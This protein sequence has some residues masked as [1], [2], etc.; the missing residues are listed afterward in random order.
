MAEDSKVSTESGKRSTKSTV[1]LT[2]AQALEILQQ[3]VINCQHAGIDASVA[4]LHGS[5][6]PTVA[7]VLANTKIVDG[8]VVPA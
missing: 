5:I 4:T 6:Y 1:G 8:N 2:P 7:I 3:A